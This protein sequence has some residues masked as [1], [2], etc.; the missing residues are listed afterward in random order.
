VKEAAYQLFLSA[1]SASWP[2]LRYLKVDFF[3][4]L[5]LRS[6]GQGFGFFRFATIL[7]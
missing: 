2:T 5:I 6:L 3:D 7:F 1:R 4:Q